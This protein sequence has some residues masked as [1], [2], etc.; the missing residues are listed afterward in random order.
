V[1][2]FVPFGPRL[3]RADAV[4]DEGRA[5]AGALFAATAVAGAA[6]AATTHLAGLG[7]SAN[8]AAT[9]AGFAVA[10]VAMLDRE[11]PI[12][13]AGAHVLF[14][15]GLLLATVGVASGVLAPDPVAGVGVT[16]GTALA[17]AGGAAAWAGLLGDGE[18]TE[19]VRQG[20]LAAV[21]PVVVAVPVL[22]VAGLLAVLS[23][24]VGG[25]V[26][27]AGDR[28]RLAGLAL[29]VAL[30]AGAGRLALGALPLARLVDRDRRPAVER[31]CTAVRRGL[32][33]GALVGSVG[34]VGLSAAGLV[35]L[36]GDVWAALPSA[37]V[38][39]AALATGGVVRVPLA[40]AGTA[41]L[42]LAAG[43][44]LAR[45]LAG[46][47]GE[48]L[49]TA[50][51]P[52][53]G[54]AV[55]L[56][57][58]SPALVVLAA[59]RADQPLT[60]GLGVAVAV[61]AT[62]AVSVLVGVAL[63]ALAALPLAARVRLLPR[64]RGG[65][66]LLAVGT[67]LVGATAGPVGAPAPAVVGC[68]GAALVAWDLGGFATDLTREVGARPAVRTLE[69]R[70]TLAALCVGGVGCLLALGAGAVGGA[71]AVDLLPAAALAALGLVPVVLLLRA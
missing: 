39:L 42:V 25:V 54:G 45:R 3:D 43:A 52:F 41:A 22:L 65:V 71:V 33:A 2:L 14:L 6:L 38:R 44:V 32:T 26:L 19:S 55:L 59:A 34:W 23:G 46:R 69:R 8:L 27:P 12:V 56:V 29:L 20:L 9:G 48:W 51:L 37:V 47:G 28:P 15:P 10:G 61:L 30:A 5:R 35:G 67:L 68:V 11:R 58:V 70:R 16:L 62:V 66:A 50:G 60:V 4:G 31:R 21:V 49:G 36:T 24:A 13:R 63:L 17:V 64:R 18:V 7:S 53:V 1:I 40:L 57:V